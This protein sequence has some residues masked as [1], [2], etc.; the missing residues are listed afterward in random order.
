MLGIRRPTIIEWL[1]GNTYED[2]R[3]WK[4][5]KPRKE[6]DHSEVVKERIRTLK[7]KRNSGHYFVGSDYV[8][9]DYAKGYPNEPVPSTWFIEEVIR[10]ANLQ[11][12]KPKEKKKSGGSKYLLFP[13]QLV[14]NLGY[15]HQSADFIGKKYITGRT[16]PINIFSRAYYSPFKLFQIKRVE[17]EK[18]RCAIEVL[19]NDWQTFPIP[20]V[21]RI[22][23]GLQFRG[24]ARG[25]RS[26]GMFLRFLLNLAVTPLFGSPSK[27][28]T[29]PAI[30]GHNRTFNEK[31]WANNYFE[32]LDQ[33]DTEC[34]RFN[35]ESLDYFHYRYASFLDNRQF[36]Y[37]GGK[38]EPTTD[39]LVTTKNRKVYFI[40]FAESYEH[41][42]PAYIDILNEKVKIPEQYTHQ[43]VFAEWDIEHEVLSIFSEYDGN[44]TLICQMK[45][46]LNLG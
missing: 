45:F 7:E 1:S 15:L 21:F 35:Q 38:N 22:D 44:S 34:T 11:T 10:D 26:V 40:R 9:M 4:A 14:K 43:F 6:T 20:D 13:E 19:K 3:G 42:C 30:E 36:R 41:S 18:S 5:D 27:P 37:L 28:W 39:R 16:E 2:S 31:I 33:I 46:K 17:A 29:N 23:N 25:K 8:Q 24:T 32:N 12:R